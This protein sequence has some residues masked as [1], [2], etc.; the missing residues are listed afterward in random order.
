MDAANRYRHRAEELRVIAEDKHT[1][2]NRRTLFKLAAD[3]DH[4]AET[5]ML[6]DRA[7]QAV[8]KL[9]LSV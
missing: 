7:N 8:R 1:V 6:I 3:Y 2:D 5:M 9:K 4:M